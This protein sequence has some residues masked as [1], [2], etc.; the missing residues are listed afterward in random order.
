MGRIRLA[1]LAALL[2]LL[3]APAAARSEP[4]SETII[5]GE[6]ATQGEYPAQGFL[7]IDDDGDGFGDFSCGGTLVST[8]KFLTAAHCATE[9]GIPFAPNQFIVGMGNV[10]VSDMTDIYAVSSVEVNSAYN[11]VT[12]QNDVAMLELS[13]DA[14]YQPLRVIG[15]DEGALWEPGDPPRGSSAGASR[16]TANRATTSSRRPCRS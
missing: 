12:F 5:N 10:R 9:A 6:P 13:R 8:R 15:T 1:L 14:P 7:Q 16:R 3:I 4:P 2:G 11:P